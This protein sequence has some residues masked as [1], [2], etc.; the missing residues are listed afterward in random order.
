MFDGDNCI[1]NALDFCSKIKGKE[2]K[3]IFNKIVEYNLQLHA[4]NGSG[5]DTWIILNSLPCDKHIVDSSKNGK[6]FISLRVFNG[7]LYNAKKKHFPQY[8]IFRCGMTLLIFSLMKLGKPVKL[9]KELLKTDMIHDEIDE[10]KYIINKDEWLFYVK[11]DVLCTVFSYARYTKAM[12]EITGFA[13]KDCLSL[14]GLGWNYFKSLGTEEG[15]PVYTYNDKYMRRFVKQSIKGGRVCAFNRYYESQICVDVL[16]I[17]SEELTLNGNVYDIIE[18]FL[19]YKIKQF[20]LLEK[21]YENH[22]NDYRDEDVE[23]KEK[24]INEKFSQLRIH[25]LIKQI[26]LAELL[27][28]FDAVSFYPCAMWD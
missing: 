10:E 19:E 14:P 26:K 13:M 11:N 8:L 21:E 4:H 12:E 27:W 18:A 3:A 24:Y 16:K 28:D 15:D 9:Q 20:K 7:Y 6:K 22:F 23:E 17:V 25:Q 1:K 2:R 5:F